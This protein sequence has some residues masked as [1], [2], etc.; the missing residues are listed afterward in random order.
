MNLE[1]ATA[2]FAGVALVRL[3]CVRPK[4]DR[5]RNLREANQ[6]TESLAK[7]QFEVRIREKRAKLYDCRWLPNCEINI[8]PPPT[9]QAFLLI[10]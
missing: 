7:I 3:S 4:L 6:H 5:Q 9:L 1:G 2:S 8:L 10:S